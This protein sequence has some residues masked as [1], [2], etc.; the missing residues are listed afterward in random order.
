MTGSPEYFQ[1]P[2]L[3]VVQ[4]RQVRSGA[5]DGAFARRPRLFCCANDIFHTSILHQ[6]G[7]WIFDNEKND[8]NSLTFYAG[9]PLGYADSANRWSYR[10]WC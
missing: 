8:L 3:N 1:L 10:C 5:V 9:A 4:N 2:W 6:A 7:F